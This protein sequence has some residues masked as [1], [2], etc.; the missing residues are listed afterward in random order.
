MSRPGALTAIG[1]AISSLASAAVLLLWNLRPQMFPPHAHDYLGGFALGVIALAWLLWQASRRS[2]TMDWV[3]AILLASAFLFWAAN[4]FWPDVRQAT[5]FNDLAVGLFV[6]D[7]F[8]SMR[9]LPES[10][11]RPLD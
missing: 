8:L 6:L 2:S 10:Q 9:P 7:V 4:Q 5:L 1:F 3:R 11:R